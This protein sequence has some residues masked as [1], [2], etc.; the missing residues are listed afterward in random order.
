V[1]VVDDDDTT[2]FMMNQ[3]KGDVTIYVVRG[4]E[5]KGSTKYMIHVV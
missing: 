5:K 3:M 2:M 1:Q 4:K